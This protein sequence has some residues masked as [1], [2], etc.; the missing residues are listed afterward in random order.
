[1]VCPPPPPANAGGIGDGPLRGKEKLL[2][3]LCKPGEVKTALLRFKDHM[4]RGAGA[5]AIGL[6]STSK[7]GKEASDFALPIRFHKANRRRLPMG[8]ACVCV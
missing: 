6:C 4:T 7:G 1:M 3:M 8:Q 5:D 2:M